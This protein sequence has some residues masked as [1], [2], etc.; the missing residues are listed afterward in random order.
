MCR[1][2][3]HRRVRRS[4]LAAVAAR[5]PNLAQAGLDTAKSRIEGREQIQR[6]NAA[7]RNQADAARQ[8]GLLALREQILTAKLNEDIANGKAGQADKTAKELFV[9]QT[10]LGHV[11]DRLKA[12]EATG[13]R[14]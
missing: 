3:P 12:E 13:R 10:A 5:N 8:A 9:V 2:P 11:S 4:N 6:G 7:Q 1:F 14:G